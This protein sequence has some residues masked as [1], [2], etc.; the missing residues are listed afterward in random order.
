M[1]RYQGWVILTK[2][3]SQKSLL[4]LVCRPC[5]DRT[6]RREGQG[7]SLVKT[8][9]SSQPEVWSR[10]VFVTSTDISLLPDPSPNMP[11]TVFI[12]TT[13]KAFSRVMRKQPLI[14]NT[15]VSL[16]MWASPEYKS[17]HADPLRIPC[18]RVT[19]VCRTSACS[20]TQGSADPPTWS[21]S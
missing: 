6:D 18:P 5:R 11:S 10:T 14:P 16:K 8:T 3:T 17:N 12:N 21:S 20:G 13:L 2:P 9:Q 7:Q 19:R 4:R 1:V 15:G